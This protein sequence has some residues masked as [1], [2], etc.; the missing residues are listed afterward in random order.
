[1]RGG[2][3]ARHAGC[4]GLGG[5]HGPDGVAFLSGAGPE[6][7]GV[8]RFNPYRRLAEQGVSTLASSLR[9]EGY[10]TVCVHP[11]P[12]SFYRR[13]RVYPHL[14]FDDFIDIAAF[15]D[16]PRSGPYVSDAAVGAHVARLIEDRDTDPRPL[17]VFVI[18]M[19]NHGPLHWEKV[20]D[21][22]ESR[23]F[24]AAAGRL[25]AGC[26][27]LIAYARHLANADAF[28][29]SLAE[30]LARADRCATLCIYG[31]H[32]PIMPTVYDALGTPDGKT[33]YLIW[34]TAGRTTGRGPTPPGSE[35]RDARHAHVADLARQ[36]LAGL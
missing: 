18:T 2:I 24:D 12:A 3:G 28:F 34:H 22:D 19:E 7:L 11:Y 20:S 32:V 29:G 21:A 14:G 25:P 36:I 35:Q 4:G 27:D 9:D 1:M 15:E 13:D 16:A 6:T 31:D 10:K 17:F 23:L 8:H 5:K 26:S 30:T 33:D